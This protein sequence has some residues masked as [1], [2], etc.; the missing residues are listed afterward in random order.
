MNLQVILAVNLHGTLVQLQSQ[1]G[2]G[3][4][5]SSLEALTRDNQTLTLNPG[6]GSDEAGGIRVSVRDFLRSFAS[7]GSG[8]SSS[9]QATANQGGGADAC[10]VVSNAHAPHSNERSLGCRPLNHENN[11]T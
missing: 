11:M 2:T 3:S 7:E 6:V 8:D 1:H 5:V 4:A 9:N 10:D